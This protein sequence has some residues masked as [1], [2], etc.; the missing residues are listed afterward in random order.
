MNNYFCEICKFTTIRKRDFMRHLKS[1]KHQIN[2]E[3]L[4]NYEEVPHKSAKCAKNPHKPSL[5]EGKSCVETS[6]TL[7]NPHK[8]SQNLTNAHVDAF[9]PESNY[10]NNNNN[11]KEFRCKICDKSFTRKDNLTR[12]INKYCNKK[13]N[14][15]NQFNNLK[16]EILILKEQV[17]INNDNSINN[18][19]NTTNTQNNIININNFGSE[20]LEMLTEKFMCDMIDKPYTAIPKMIK[21][22][23][24]NDKYPENKNIRMFNKRCDKLQILNHKIWKYVS[25]DETISELVNDKNYEM[26]KFYENNKDKFNDTQKRRYEK[27]QEKIDLEDKTV[28]KNIKNETDLIFWNHM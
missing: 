12:H 18:S 14:L 21:K 24:F 10:E 8:P 23:H 7:T 25:K 5:R 17:I 27:F 11:K 15:E 16:D 6:Q 26:Y 13:L 2:S 3:N 20:N 22:I 19:N 4:N 1:T 28:N 9:T